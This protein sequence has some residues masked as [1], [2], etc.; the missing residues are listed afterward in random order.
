MKAAIGRGAPRRRGLA[1]LE[2]TISTLLLAAALVIA[3]Q[4]LGWL[5][6]QRR[7][8][9]RRQR[10]IQ[11][12]ANLMERL[13]ARPF[14]ELTPELAR[15]VALSP[16]SAAVLRDGTLDVAIAPAPGEPTSKSITVT[17]RWGDRSGVGPAPVRLVAWVHRRSPK[18]GSR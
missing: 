10:A 4:S 5:A 2:L 18:G 16:A 12:A 9:E 15:S 17:I 1:L 13:S 3:V 11:E 8:A 14:D 7:G 6:S